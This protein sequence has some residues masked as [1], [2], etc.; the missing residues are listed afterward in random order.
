MSLNA[1][2][3]G[4]SVHIAF[5][6]KRNAG[7]SS[8]INAVTN[9]NVSVVSDVKGT[10]TD[11][12][13][14]TMELLP[15]G[16]VV[17]ID[18]PGADDEGVLGE[19]RV[20]KTYEVLESADIAVVVTEAGEPFSDFENE[21]INKIKEKN[22]P[23]IIAKNKSDLK[24]ST[25]NEENE[26]DVS[27]LTGENVNKLKAMV[28]SVKPDAK[29][30]GRIIADLLD[31]DDVVVL[32]IP[33][34]EAA[35][36]GRLILPQ[37]QTI[38]DILD[39]RANA[40]CV[41]P[42][43][44]EKMLR[45]LGKSVKIVVTD[46]QAFAEVSKIV[47]KELPLTSFSILMARYKGNLKKNAESAQ[48]LDKLSDGDTVLISEACT[49]HRQCNDI[50]TVKLPGLIG[51]YTGK[52]I[53]FEY[54]SG[55]DFP[56]NL[57]KYKLVVHCGACMINEKQMQARIKRCSEQNVPIT[58]YGIAIAKMTGILERSLAAF[59]K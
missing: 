46:S 29:P 14:K 5:F 41:R 21:L 23:L 20:K 2:P 36:K 51:K 57:E 33:I 40:V 19:M 11:P 56:E 4:E 16:P 39:T 25:S 37:Q 50:G 22:L 55:N 59:E 30:N 43:Q 31:A 32:V 47:P 9:Q 7:K 49:H 45:F 44:L 38:R 6:G 24:K 18:T 1:A 15:I 8:L 27:A 28:A 54:T 26:I 53:N 10:T 58:N 35:P 12:V 34:D 3:T 48:M 17:I 52:K 13:K 42:E